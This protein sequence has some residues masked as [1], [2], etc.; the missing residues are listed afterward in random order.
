MQIEPGVRPP[1]PHEVGMATHYYNLN[2]WEV[3]TVRGDTLR[4]IVSEARLSSLR[5]GEK[6]KRAYVCLQQFYFT[7]ALSLK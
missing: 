3:E 6:E 2:P 7:E 5:L 4:C 1:E